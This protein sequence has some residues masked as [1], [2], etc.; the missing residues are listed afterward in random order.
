MASG[1]I[2][3]LA[4][5]VTRWRKWSNAASSPMI[6]MHRVGEALVVV[7]GTSGRCST[8]RTTS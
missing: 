6:D 3:A 8:S 4:T 2:Q 5:S 7:G 1:G